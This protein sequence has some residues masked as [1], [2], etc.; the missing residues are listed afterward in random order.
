MASHI[1]GEKTGGAI[2]MAGTAEDIFR[3]KDDSHITLYIKIM[4]KIFKLKLKS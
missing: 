1:T 2:Y 4:E 3:R